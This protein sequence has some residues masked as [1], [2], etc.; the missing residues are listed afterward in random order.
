MKSTKWKA[1]N[2]IKVYK[3]QLKVIGESTIQNDM[4]RS[5]I[6]YE[7]KG[8]AMILAKLSAILILAFCQNIYGKPKVD[9]ST[10]AN[11]HAG[12]STTY[13]TY[14]PTDPIQINTQNVSLVFKV[15][16]KGTLMQQ[17]FGKRLTYA[18]ISELTPS[19]LIESYI[20]GGSTDLYEPAIRVVHSDGNPS[21]VLKVTDVESKQVS[22]DNSLTR[23]I[24][25]DPEYPVKVI[26]NFST[27]NKEDIIQSWMEISHEEPKAIRVTNFA[28][29]MLHFNND[30][31]YLTQFHGDWAEE[32]KMEEAPLTSGIKI[33]DSKLGT[34]ENMFQSPMF[35]LSLN[36]PATETKGQVI[37][38]TLAWSGNFQFL[39]EKDALGRLRVVAGMNPYASDYILDAGKTLTT[40]AFIYTYSATGKGQAS[41]N[42]HDWARN[43]GVLDG[44]GA[45][46]TLLNNWEAT[47]FDFNESKLDTLFAEAKSLGVDL[48]LLDDGWFGNKYPRNNDH[49]SLGD[50][51]ANKRKLPHGLG[52]LIQ[53]ATKNG[54]K[55]GIWLEPEM[56]SPKSELYEKHPDWIL[57]LPNRPEHYFRNELV[58][59]LINP[60][61]QDFVYQTID[62]LLSK[63]A[64]IAFIKWDCNRMMTN[65]YSAYLK[66]RQSNLYI[67]YV[68]SLYKVL[69]RLRG[70]YPNLPMMLCSGGGGRTD[71]GA[72]KYFTEFW[73][74]DNTDPY[75]RI[76]I[77]WGYSYFFP[78]KTLAAH[79]TSWGK[80][81]LKFRTDVAMMG[82]LGFDIDVSQMTSDELKFSQDAV[83]TY[84]TLSKI[85][86]DGDLYRLIDP[87]RHQRAVLMYVDKDKNSSVV[88]SYN[89]HPHYGTDWTAVTLEGLDPAK[90][91]RVEETNLYPGSKSSLPENGKLFSGEYL[92]TVGLNLSKSDVLSSSVIKLIASTKMENQTETKTRSET[93]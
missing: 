20:A 51:Q 78:A 3:E 84:H 28:S 47:Q 50:W 44:N 11:R 93:K 88:F 70:K 56:I 30:N 1:Q 12:A 92:M 41:R 36:S 43:Y 37:A 24:L 75:E 91:Y 86:W 16:Q 17:Y 40:P 63:N 9:L 32:M 67:D 23:I 81:S 8:R 90:T 58:L 46:M 53:E 54:V 45:R 7:K 10:V 72:L 83:K 21:L 62:D 5:R 52:H 25:K 19:S 42:F 35:M 74:S 31:Y 71:Y 29:A 27:Y 82:R 2:C 66:E 38:G 18:S 13:K 14:I 80:Q 49:T 61:V 33:I 55:F 87:Y 73:P 60:A 48:F 79:V 34:R 85:V 76:Y 57:K 69:D 6:L 59:D 22:P 89:L 15:S 26:L 39:F 4:K 65:A 68:H 64:G 77:Q